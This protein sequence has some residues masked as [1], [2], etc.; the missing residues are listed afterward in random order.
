L[1]CI[2]C[3]RSTIF[4]LSLC[5]AQVLLVVGGEVTNS[6]ET[7]VVVLWCGWCAFNAL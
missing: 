4:A 7:S 6:A 5:H 2:L 1:L 3:I